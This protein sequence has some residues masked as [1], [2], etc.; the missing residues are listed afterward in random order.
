[1]KAKETK[2]TKLCNQEPIK[3]TKPLGS[4]QDIEVVVESAKFDEENNR[5]M[6]ARSSR[7]GQDIAEPVALEQQS[8]YDFATQDNHSTVMILGTTW[9]TE[10]D[11]FEYGFSKLVDF[12]KILPSTK[13]SVL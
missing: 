5:E 12:I 6:V 3:I 1:M 4:D 11:E 7:Y 9:N 10:S 8:T 13:R 2:L